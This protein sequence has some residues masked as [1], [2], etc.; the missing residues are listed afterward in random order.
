M[1]EVGKKCICIENI[2]WFPTSGIFHF[3]SRFPKKDDIFTIIDLEEENGIIYLEFE[4]IPGESW[5][6]ASFRPLDDFAETILMK[7]IKE[8]KKEE[9][10]EVAF[11]LLQIHGK[12]ILKKT[13][14]C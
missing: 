5:D 14:Y 1:F 2:D 12:I 6:A 3:P 9:L 4:E 8:I 7:I 13:T 10:E 11:H